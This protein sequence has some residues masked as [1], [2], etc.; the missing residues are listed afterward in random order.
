MTNGYGRAAGDP[1][2]PGEPPLLNACQRLKTSIGRPRRN[3]AELP[4]PQAADVLVD[5]DG[6][7]AAR[8]PSGSRSPGS[9]T[10]AR[11]HRP[12]GDPRPG[13]QRL[14]R[15]RPPP[16]C[17]RLDR[18]VGAA[19]PLLDAFEPRLLPEHQA[20]GLASVVGRAVA[21]DS[22]EMDGVAHPPHDARSP[23][24]V[25]SARCV[26]GSMR[27][28]Y[29]S[30]SGMNGRPSSVPLASRV[31]KISA[32]LRTRTSF[33]W[34]QVED[35]RLVQRLAGRRSHDTYP[36]DERRS[37]FRRSVPSRSSSTVNHAYPL[38]LSPAGRAGS[39]AGGA[40]NAH[41]FLRVALSRRARA[42]GA[43]R[44]A[45]TCARGLPDAQPSHSIA[46]PRRS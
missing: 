40:R 10:G 22:L 27:P 16:P 23:A 33:T 14:G 36:T 26:T 25:V 39:E 15:H 7:A 28:Q 4:V 18:C 44:F 34:S 30:I 29:L 19:S 38:S 45:D 13:D 2:A 42:R 37:S 1:Q 12:V 32:A 24:H 5:L 31:A 11:R 8:R 21:A 35:R 3:F 41:A 20:G 43:A 6:T 17:A 46:A 9:G